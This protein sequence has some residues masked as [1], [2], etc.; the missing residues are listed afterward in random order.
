MYQSIQNWFQGSTKG[1]D[2]QKKLYGK[3]AAVT[4]ATSGIG[5]AITEDLVKRGAKVLMLCRDI[6]KATELASKFNILS[7]TGCVQIYNL[8]LTSLSSVK[9]CAERILTNEFR[10]DYLVNNAGVMMCPYTITEGKDFYIK[11]D[12]YFER[13]IKLRTLAFKV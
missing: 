5:E 3:V 7:E 6:P 4:G 13:L 1:S 10:L 8:D 11:L 2:N 9:N 12:L